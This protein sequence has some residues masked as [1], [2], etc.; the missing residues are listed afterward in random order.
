MGHFVLRHF[1]PGYILSCEILSRFQYGDILSWRHFVLR[2]FVLRHIVL[3]PHLHVTL[4]VS[5]NKY[6][7][8]LERK[9]ES[10]T[11]CVSKYESESVHCR[12]ERSFVRKWRS[13]ERL[14]ERWWHGLTIGYYY[15]WWH[16]S[17]DLN[18]TGSPRDLLAQFGCFVERCLDPVG[19]EPLWFGSVKIL[20]STHQKYGQH[21]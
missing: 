7:S 16:L 8:S 17:M 13:I 10:A 5:F 18:H 9:S 20:G 19:G 1:V 6:N 2:H 12:E 11:V 14:Y 4:N 3:V 21:T 15:Y